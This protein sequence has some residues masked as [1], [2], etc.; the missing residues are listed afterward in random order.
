MRN[1]KNTIA[2]LIGASSG[3]GLATAKALAERGAHIV[4][5]ARKPEGLEQA[6]RVVAAHRQSA[7]QLV[8]WKTM[9]I[10]N[11]QEV[12][13]VLG[14]A[15]AEHGVPDILINL[16][17]RAY[18]RRFTDISFDDFTETMNVNLRGTWSTVS[19]LAPL[20][21]EKG[22]CIV[23]TS[24][25]AGLIGV[26]G[27]ADYCASK[28]G[29]IGFSEVLRSEL[30][31]DGISVSVLCPPDT[32]TPGFAVENQ[33]KPEETRAISAGAKLMSPENVAESLIRGLRR[34]R[35]LIVPGF[36]NRITVGLARTAPWLV[37]MVTDRIVR[38]VGR[39]TR[40]L[41]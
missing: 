20:M 10:T 13:R 38:K 7:D 36:G 3:I 39:S 6:S 16:A 14:D 15:A 35:R 2:Y 34:N 41:S 9:D 28:F 11:H 25:L 29:V 4:L 1:F 40:G 12:T 8:A 19:V 27:Y 5:F 32:D 31:P 30:K 17:G 33:T 23:N 26:Y 37:E 24:S 18:P 22:G 21:K